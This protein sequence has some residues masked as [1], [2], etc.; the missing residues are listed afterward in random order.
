MMFF[1]R[2]L[3]K[4]LTLSRSILLEKIEARDLDRRT[5]LVGDKLTGWPGSKHHSE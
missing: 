4:C 2:I 5:V 1:I 3:T